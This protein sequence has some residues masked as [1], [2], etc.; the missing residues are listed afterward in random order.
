MCC[1][2]WHGILQRNK[3]NGCGG[4]VLGMGMC[5]CEAKSDEGEGRFDSGVVRCVMCTRFYEAIRCSSSSHSAM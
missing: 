5:L 1:V 4:R 3:R 2:L